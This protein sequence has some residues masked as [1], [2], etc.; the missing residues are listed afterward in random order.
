MRVSTC[1]ERHDSRLVFTNV[2][3]GKRVVKEIQ[4]WE[5]RIVR[6][7]VKLYSS[8]IRQ[9]HMRFY[10]TERYSKH[11]NR[12]VLCG[13]RL[14]FALFAIFVSQPYNHRDRI[15]QFSHFSGDIISPCSPTI[16]RSTTFEFPATSSISEALPSAVRAVSLTF[17]LSFND[18][19][20]RIAI[21]IAHWL[22]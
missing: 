16:P 15:I 19:S 21:D 2:S 1:V 10:S 3:R 5:K 22:P 14:H 18:I 8:V 6:A 4:Y 20:R 17:L 7:R 12:S 13:T 11:C 9:S